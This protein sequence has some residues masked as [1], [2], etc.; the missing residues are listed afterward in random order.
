MKKIN[1]LV[2]GIIFAFAIVFL[3]NNA[4]AAGVSYC[5]E[6]TLVQTDGS[7]GA[8]CQNVPDVSRCDTSNGLRV[9]PTSC[10]ATSYCKL[11][12]CV[13]PVEGVC[14]E[15]TPQRTCEEPQGNT[16]GLWFN[17]AP[18]KIP[19]CQLGCCLIGEQAAFT[20]QTRCKQLSSLY[21]LESNYRTDIRTEAQCIASAFSELKG[22]CVFEENL[23][24]TCRF[25]TRKDCQAILS[26]APAAATNA[27]SAATNSGGGFFSSLFGG[28]Q[29]TSNAATTNKTAATNLGF[30]EG[31]L[32]SD[33]KLGTI[34]GPS[35]K[36]K[37][38]DGRDEVF[39]VDTCGNTANIYDSNRQNDRTYW[40]KIIPKAESCGFTDANGNA[41]SASCGNC[42]YLSGSAG[43][44]FDRFRDSTAPKMGDYIC[45]SL[46]CKFDS[47]GDGT[48]E[49]FKHG[50][51][52]CAPSP[53]T[54]GIS[55]NSDGSVVQ[56]N[57]NYAK[58]N[59][60]GSRYYREVCYNG[61]V[62]IEPCADFRQ[63]ICIQSSIGTTS[64][65]F[66][67]AACRV[68][69]WQDCIAQT[70]K[71]DCEN[72]EKRDCNWGGGG[73]CTDK[74][75]C[76]GLVNA[77]YLC[78]PKYSPGF[79]FWTEGDAMSLCFQASRDCVVKVKKNVKGI[80]EGKTIGEM[81]KNADS[82]GDV[83][84]CDCLTDEWLQKANNLCLAMGDCGA[85]VNYINKNGF[86]T[87]EDL[88][89]R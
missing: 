51:T 46:N 32:C 11:G 10:E 64:S 75:S 71:R 84:G 40:D 33:E 41:N 5:C 74:E 65:Q 31:S 23:Q 81:C 57:I 1:L 69:K 37:I 50:E 56:K 27:N 13:N 47:N 2:F 25:T 48:P 86:N 70:T 63:E 29:T 89:K 68:N 35:V 54:S 80:L 17:S 62:T 44:L 78:F 45:R 28:S 8:W 12:T 82:S 59:V 52:W 7:G 66:R 43:A 18:D 20:T 16:K 85:S 72:S 24:R 77:Q 34:C 9:V 30:Y 3:S 73:D 42:D 39:F 36:T 53:G 58:E 61:E 87:E 79:N 21:G 26:S 88:V 49:D 15:N 55:V 60:P 76:R 67:T 38:V 83:D 4:N 6:K 14:M 19:Q 22:A